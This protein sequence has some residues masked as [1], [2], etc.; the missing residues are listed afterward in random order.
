MQMYFY[1]TKRG[2]HIYLAPGSNTPCSATENNFTSF[3]H[4]HLKNPPLKLTK[5]AIFLLLLFVK[6]QR[7]LLPLPQGVITSPICR[8]SHAL[9]K[10]LCVVRHF[11]S[12]GVAQCLL[13]VTIGS[14]PVV[15]VV[16]GLDQNL[17]PIW[18]NVAG[19]G[20]VVAGADVKVEQRGDD[21]RVGPVPAC[22]RQL[23]EFTPRVQHFGNDEHVSCDV[24]H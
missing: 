16:L 12:P 6:I 10:N 9:P 15:H 21:D 17:R 22:G 8:K 20:V 5:F 11:R 13:D 24:D 2:A 4:V 23:G 19:H 14:L 1:K 3:H 18:A 7:F